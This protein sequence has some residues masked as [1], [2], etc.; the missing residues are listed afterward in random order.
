MDYMPMMTCIEAGYPAT[1]EVIDSCSK[2]ANLDVDAINKCAASP[3]IY[4]PLLQQAAQVTAAAKIPGTPQSILNGEAINTKMLV[5]QVCTQFNVL[6]P[7]KVYPVGCPQA[8]E[9]VQL[10][11]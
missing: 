8:G 10:I 6:N 9:G 5:R 7:E 3:D 11:N 1:Q 4:S 2:S